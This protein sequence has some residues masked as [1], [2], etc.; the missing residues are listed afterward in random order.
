VWEG[1]EARRRRW[2]HRGVGRQVLAD[3]EWRRRPG[4]RVWATGAGVRVSASEGKFDDYISST[5]DLS[6]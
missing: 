6:H 3:V 1:A 4:G 2:R 5:R